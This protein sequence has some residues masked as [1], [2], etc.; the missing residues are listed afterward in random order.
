MMKIEDKNGSMGVWEYG[1]SSYFTF[2]QVHEFP[3]DALRIE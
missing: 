1:G 2:F 3:K